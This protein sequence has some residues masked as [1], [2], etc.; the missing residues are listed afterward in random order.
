MSPPSEAPFDRRRDGDAR[1]FT[2]TATTAFA[3]LQ[4]LPMPAAVVGLADRRLLFANRPMTDRCGAGIAAAADLDFASLFVDPT[5]FERLLQRIDGDGFRDVLV[6]QQ[7]LDHRR[8]WVSLSGS[9]LDWG[10]TEAALLLAADAEERQRLKAAAEASEER[11]R[12]FAEIASDWLWEMDAELRDT[13]FSPR[14]TEITGDPPEWHYGKTRQELGIRVAGDDA[15]PLQRR[16]SYRNVV[17]SR[18]N[19]AG[20]RIWMRSSAR[21]RYA[22]DGRFLGYRGSGTDVSAEVLAETALRESEE[23]FRAIFDNSPAAIFLRDPDGRYLLVN[24]T[25]VDWFGLPADV[26]VGRTIHDM[27]PADFAARYEMH[28]RAVMA[29]G[30]AEMRETETPFADGSLRVTRVYKFP[31]RDPEGGIYG[32]G[33]IELDVTSLRAA[34]RDLA[35]AEKAA[36]DAQNMLVAALDGADSGV[37]L[38]DAEGRLLLCNARY[39]E[40]AG[41]LAP[42]LV[43]GYSL[44]DYLRESL[45]RGVLELPDGM[46]ADAWIAW[47]GQAPVS[48]PFEICRSGRWLLLRESLAAGGSRLVVTTDISALKEREAALGQ[49]KEAAEQANRAKTQFLANMSHELRT[50]LNAVIGFAEAL[51]EGVAGELPERAREYVND[52]RSAGAHLYALIEEVLDLARIEAGRYRLHDEPVELN[53]LVRETLRVIQAQADIKQLSIALALPAAGIVVTA[54]RRAL[55]QM[56]LNLLSNAVKFTQRGRVAVSIARALDGVRVAVEDTGIGISEADLTRVTEPF[57]QVEA[58][59]SRAYEG[60]GLGLAIVSRLIRLHGGDIDIASR[61]GAGTRVTLLLPAERY[62]SGG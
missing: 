28:D 19:R 53:E 49:A 51:D 9:R 15:D 61:L 30:S 10:G 31:I 56:L 8:F 54:D 57:E 55:R 21:P 22:P 35:E 26:V 62:L 5:E 4:L 32:I 38:W 44:A 50:P 2:G 60:T 33:G 43:R 25:Y 46:T 17:F 42:L 40:Q 48:Q 16:E 34:E 47:R 7:A 37:A 13:Y 27:F 11:F 59:A 20:R 12:D 18:V 1:P 6:Q 39:R 52:I 45:E 58:A 29:S 14:V 36:Q 3:L 41:P 23:R 24:R